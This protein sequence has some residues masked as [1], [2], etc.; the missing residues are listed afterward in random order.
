MNAHIVSIV[1][2]RITYGRIS[3]LMDGNTRQSVT[4]NIASIDL[5]SACNNIHAVPIAISGLLH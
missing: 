5:Q 2:V 3:S 1:N 4:L